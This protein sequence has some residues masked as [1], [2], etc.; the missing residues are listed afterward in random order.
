MLISPQN[1]TAPVNRIRAQ[2]ALAADVAGRDPAAVTLV[3]V[4]KDK[5]AEYV[6][7][8]ATLGVTD[9]G[10]NYVKEALGKMDEL[11]GLP[12]QWHFI[13]ALQSNKTRPVAERFAWVHS[14]D[15]MS[16]AR[17]LSEQRPFHAPSLNVCI[18][19]ALVDEPGKGGVEPA[20]LADLAHAVAALPQLKLRGLMCLPPPLPDEDARRKLFARLRRHLEEL[21]SEGLG[22][23]TLSMGMSA[24]FQ[25]AI[26][27]GATHVRIGT[28]LFGSR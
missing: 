10:E 27:E 7:A 6:R 14:L 19:V 5:A 17:R 11:A 2:I 1:L 21:N 18:Q 26:A 20:A 15:R 16:V 9:F 4:T 22:L 24:D 13:G 3:A 12:V 23:D 28:A 25:A 8:A